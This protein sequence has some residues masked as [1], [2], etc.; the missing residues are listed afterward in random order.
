MELRDYQLDLV[1]NV[2]DLLFK[3]SNI[4]VVAPPGIGKTECFIAIC[5]KAVQSKKDIKILI[6]LNKVMLVEQTAR[7][8][9][10]VIPNVGVF[11]ATLKKTE[12]FNVT[13][14]SIQS[15]NKI[16]MCKI[17]LVILDECHN[18][19]ADEATHYGSF[20]KKIAHE[21]LKVIGFTA[22]PYR[23][24]CVMYGE[25]K[26]FD[27]VDHQIE[28]A[29]MIAQGWLVPPR[30]KASDKEFK[31]DNLKIVGGDYDNKQISEL[32]ENNESAM[33]QVEDAIPKLIGRKKIAWACATINHAEII[34]KL[35]S[36]SVVI[37]SAMGKEAQNFNKD[38]FENGD[39]SNIVFVSMLSEGVD[40]PSIDA[41]V[42]LRPTR[43]IVRYI[44]TV[45]RALRPFGDKKDALILDYGQVVKNC[46]PIDKPFIRVPNERRNDTKR[47]KVCEGCFEVLH[48]AVRICPD[49]G[50]VF[51]S[52]PTPVKLTKKAESNFSIMSNQIEEMDCVSVNLAKHNSKNGNECVKIS[53][54]SDLYGMF[55]ISEYFIWDKDYAHKKLIQRLNELG[56]DYFG[57][58]DSQVKAKAVNIPKKVVYTKDG[59]FFKISRLVW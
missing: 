41:L 52:E 15:I 17:N 27:K 59:K 3:K 39:C 30:M 28:I 36:N 46:G 56:C 6:L 13:V 2:W 45:G 57:D 49:C 8:I 33:S 7:R 32:T 58:I 47:M 42:F 22:T 37:H 48:P 26:M 4:L 14:A 40:I 23:N 18:V 35:V 43:S 54:Y 1:G 51:F 44:Q 10:K 53:Y 5:D 55:R 11:C 12:L 34:G 29:N 31:T 20:L 25:G 38:R 9:N 16:D 21:K 50:H 19:S 24:S